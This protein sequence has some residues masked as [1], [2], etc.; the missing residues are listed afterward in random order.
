M[1][2]AIR[3]LLKEELGIEMIG[4]AV[5]LAETLQLTAAL[6]PDVVL[7]DPH[8]DDERAAPATDYVAIS[9]ARSACR[10]NAL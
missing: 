8:M 3:K 7:M 6:K 9:R 4:T 2:A 5:S 10:C 1:R